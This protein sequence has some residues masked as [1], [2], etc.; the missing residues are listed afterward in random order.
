MLTKRE[1]LDNKNGRTQA[2]REKGQHSF[3]RIGTYL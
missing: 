2:N 3:I 1:K